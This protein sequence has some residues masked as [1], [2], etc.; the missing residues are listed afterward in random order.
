MPDQKNVLYTLKENPSLKYILMLLLMGWIVFAISMFEVNQGFFGVT[1]GLAIILIL[2][3]RQHE[4]VVTENS[5]IVKEVPL[6]PV[7]K[8][9]AT[10]PYS[11][12]QS[13]SYKDGELDGFVLLISLFLPG[14]AAG[15]KDPEIYITLKDGKPITL[16]AAKYDNSQNRQLVEI[17][18]SKLQSAN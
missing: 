12:I 16:F 5:L 14:P 7:Y 10:Y 3:I 9:Q 4:M 2:R 17:V 6:I 8:K 1:I 15:D 13:I 11:D 18:N